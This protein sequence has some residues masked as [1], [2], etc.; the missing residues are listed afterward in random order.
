M[1]AMDPT[2]GG[3]LAKV[4]VANKTAVDAAVQ[5]ARQAFDSGPWWNEWSAAKRSR[6]LTRLAGLVRENRKDLSRI[7]SLDVGMPRGMA[8]KLRMGR[9]LEF[10]KY[11][12]QGHRTIGNLYLSFMEAAGIRSP[13][14]FGQ[15]D[16]NLKDLDLKG[17]LQEL[18]VG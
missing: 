5:A 1:D 18:M 14:S 11:R 10:P 16:A 13:E 8:D 2:T 12:E 9:Y 7:E 3:T 4:P 15:P 6:C 17:P